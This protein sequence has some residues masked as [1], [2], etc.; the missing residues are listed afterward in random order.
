MLVMR[1]GGWISCPPKKVAGVAG[2][3][4]RG[5]GGLLCGEPEPVREHRLLATGPCRGADSELGGIVLSGHGPCH[6][7]H[8]GRPR[9]TVALPHHRAS[10]LRGRRLRGILSRARGLLRGV[11]LRATLTGASAPPRPR[12]R[13]RLL[14]GDPK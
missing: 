6:F 10:L 2:E 11:C 13:A 12:L 4:E 9:P 5:R 3:R 8:D 1:F 7:V 14:E